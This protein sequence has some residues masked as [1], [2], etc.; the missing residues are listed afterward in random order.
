M[1]DIL[2]TAGIEIAI[3]ILL[4]LAWMFTVIVVVGKQPPPKE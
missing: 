3:M 2:A 1:T 4:A